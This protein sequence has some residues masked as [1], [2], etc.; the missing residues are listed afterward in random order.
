M[1]VDRSGSLGGIRR[2][3][4]APFGEELSAGVGI[5]SASNGY[6]GDAVRQKYGS[7]E[8]DDETG[9]DYFGARYF[10]SVQGRFTSYDPVWV[11]AKRII[12]PQ[13]LNLYSYVRNNPLKFVDPDGT[14]LVLTAKNKQDAEKK[15]EI[16]L[17]GFEKK[18]RSHVKL[19]VGN[20]QNGFKKGQFGI[21]VDK[22]HKSAS[23]NFQWAQKAANDSTAIG[24]ITV[25][26]Q[27]ETY[28][29][30]ERVFKGGQ[31]SLKISTVNMGPLSK[32]FEGYTFFEHRGKFEDGISYAKDVSEI[33][34][35]GNQI[36][37]EISATMHH[38]TRHLVLGDFG[39]TAL[40][41]KHSEPGQPKTLADTETDKADKEARKN[42]KTP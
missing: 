23:E 42:A 8:R 15:F 9:L 25:V 1:V 29:F 33:I 5:R 24:K 14:D 32:E 40:N 22:K 35:H 11:T 13:Q 19:V 36:N 7:H 16:Y 28:E 37:T 3:D 39:R 4:F 31:D 34:V 27:G 17:L 38:E 6:S 2:H 18:D 41:S 10:A 12:D 20:G 30:S 26:R 21:E